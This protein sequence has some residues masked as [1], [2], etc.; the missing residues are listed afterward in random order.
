MRYDNSTLRR[1]DRQ[2]AEERALELLRRG[3][4]GFLAMASAEGGYGIPINYA[5][6]GDVIYLHCAPEG[7]KLRALEYDARVSFCVVGCTRIVPEYFTTEYESVIATGQAR[8]VAD[9]DERR[10]ALSLIVEKYA[11]EHIAEG[12][13]AIERSLPRTAIIAIEVDHLSGKCKR[14]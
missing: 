8:V 6:D 12:L 5:L 13:Q 11:A 1:Q 7:R 10:R 9:D 3:E 14:E 2:L 4:Y